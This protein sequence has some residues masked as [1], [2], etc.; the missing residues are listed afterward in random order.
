VTDSGSGGLLTPFFHGEGGYCNLLHVLLE[1]DAPL[2]RE[3]RVSFSA[4]VQSVL[5]VATPPSPIQTEAEYPVQPLGKRSQALDLLVR[6]EGDVIGIEA[7]VFASSARQGQLAAQYEG[8]RQK[9]A[10]E[11]RVHLLLIYPTRNTGH[12]SEVRLQGDGDRTGVISWTEILDCFPPIPG[13]ESET[14]LPILVAEA[15]TRLDTIL[16]TRLPKTV[17]T[18]KRMAV[19]RAMRDAVVAF[20]GVLA[21]KIPGFA[22][23]RWKPH[24]WRDPQIDLCYGPLIDPAG[25]RR[26]GQ[27]LGVK[28]F[29]TDAAEESPRV[30]LQVR[31]ALE[32][33]G[34]KAYGA[35]FEA[36]RSACIARLP[37]RKDG[38]H[39]EADG[40]SVC[41]ELIATI[42]NDTLTI[43]GG[44][45]HQVLADRLVDYAEAFAELL[46]RDAGAA[47]GSGVSRAV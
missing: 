33:K 8:L 45:A 32:R 7:K 37:P 14:L 17:V 30:R 41:D 42:E 1:A 28:A 24:F 11:E 36:T 39:L 3:F 35:D 25:N 20:N 31:F 38:C 6:L 2:A 12:C 19:K 5:G 43:D 34:S 46:V 16:R 10:P 18:A 26:K 44:A 23:W 29:F 15:R 22:R 9:T 13:A 47:S 40:N 21:G 27:S 4:L